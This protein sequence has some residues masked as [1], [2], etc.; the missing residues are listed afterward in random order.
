MASPQELFEHGHP[1]D[2]STVS[3]YQGVNE[4]IVSMASSV[5]SDN[6]LVVNSATS[7]QELVVRSNEVTLNVKSK[8]SRKR[9]LTT[10]SSKTSVPVS[11]SNEKV[12]KPFWNEFS[13]EWSQRLWSCIETGLQEL[14]ATSWTSSS[15]GLARNSWFT[16]KM[17]SSL[18]TSPTTSL[19]TSSRLLPTSSPHIT[20]IVL[21]KI[22]NDENKKLETE[23]KRKEEKR[24][25]MTEEE[26]TVKKKKAPATKSY[27]KSL[28]ARRIR[29]H[30][31]KEQREILKR[32]FGA[33]RFCYNLLVAANR[34]VGKGGVNLA[35]LRKTVKDAHEEH[36]WLNDV[37]GE[38]KDVAVRDMDKARKAHFAKLA[39]KKQKDPGARHDAVFKFRSKK[40]RQESFEVRGR[41]MT[42]ERGSF[43]FIH[44]S[45]IKGSE[46][47]PSEVD[48]AVRFMR[49]RLGHYYL[50]VPVQVTKRDENQT[51]RTAESIV[52]LDPGVRTFQTTYDVSG[53]TTEWGKGDMSHIFLLC[54]RADKIQGSLHEKKGTKRRGAKRMWL[55]ML[56][57]IKHKVKEIHCKLAVWLCENYKVILIPKF[58]S[59]RM[60]KRAERKINTMTARNMLTWSHYRFRELLKTKAEL[61]PWVKVI[62]CD[63]P[64][65]SK[66]CGCCGELNNKLGGAKIF[67]CNRCDY[68]ADRDINGA[69]NILLR[70]LSLFCG[71]VS[72]SI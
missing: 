9:T 54:R 24:L 14:D 7:T 11:T 10:N 67:K 36:V 39:K 31:T 53:L 25:K 41:D 44:L 17:M 13:P 22:A 60:V 61:Y 66:T 12:C 35:S 1:P 51:P 70:Y 8:I 43:A 28:R 5:C 62:E 59:S 20:D 32:W 19:T 30:P 37:P 3:V 46:T 6:N 55:R 38:V 63:E 29:I 68:V 49:N 21:Q 23:K 50:I 52:S 15:Q 48:T 65:T 57:K 33:V 58:E 47:I 42:R 2:D 26:G 56:E 4:C 64:Y 45:K 16:V 40:D 27:E 69:R 72:E 71:N 34:N 18:M